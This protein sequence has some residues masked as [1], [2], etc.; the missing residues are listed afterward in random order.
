MRV[1]GETDIFSLRLPEAHLGLDRAAEGL[2]WGAEGLG[3]TSPNTAPPH[4]LSYPYIFI[5]FKCT[6]AYLCTELFPTKLLTQ[7]LHTRY[8]LH[9]APTQI[10]SQPPYLSVKNPVPRTQLLHKY[11][12]I[13]KH[14]SHPTSLLPL[15]RHSP[16]IQLASISEDSLW[17]RPGAKPSVAGNQE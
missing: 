12:S 4:L 17:G 10:S 13:S 15:C 8:L 16:S 5:L 6:P 7:F 11:T 2:D 3:L 14:N 9:A 1:V